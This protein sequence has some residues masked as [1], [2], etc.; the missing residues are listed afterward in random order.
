MRGF[1]ILFGLVLL[2]SCYTERRA[3]REVSRAKE[4][5]PHLF[6]ADTVSDTTYL[7]ELLPVFITE[8]RTDTLLVTSSDTDSVSVDDERVRTVVVVERDS[9]TRWRIKTVVKADTVE[10]PIQVPVIRTEIEREVVIKKKSCWW[11]I[12]LSIACAAVI[13]TIGDR[14]K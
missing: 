1:F 3:M 12:I 10:V 4:T 6:S 13:V 11:M 5:F 14:V 8:Y 9:V 7:K 2:C